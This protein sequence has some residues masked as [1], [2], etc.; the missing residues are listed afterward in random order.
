[1]LE[2]I[3][4][5]RIVSKLASD[6]SGTISPDKRTQIRFDAFFGIPTLGFNT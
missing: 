5:L 4:F 1:M 6:F 2:V 3:R